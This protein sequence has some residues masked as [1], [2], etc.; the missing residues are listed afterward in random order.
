MLIDE[1]LEV[2]GAPPGTGWDPGDALYQ[3]RPLRRMA[4]LV[5]TMMRARDKMVIDL[6]ADYVL[7]LPAKGYGTIEFSMSASRRAALVA[8]GRAAMRSHLDG[9]PLQSS[10]ALSAIERA[11]FA[12]RADEIASRILGEDGSA[13]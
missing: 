2:P 9:L 13:N 7:R 6:Y 4:Q 10:A 3:Y 12:A 5:D 8:A 1:Q 11:D